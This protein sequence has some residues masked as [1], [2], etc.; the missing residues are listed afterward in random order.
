MSFATADKALQIVFRSPN[1]AIKIEFQ[2]GEP[3][4]NFDLIRHVVTKAKQINEVEKR[5]LEFV[6]ATTLSLITDD[7]LDFCKEHKIFL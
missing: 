5:N 4:L 6:I 7:I 2:G 1:P 3:L